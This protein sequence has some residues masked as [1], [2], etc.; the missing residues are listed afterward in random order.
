VADLSFT[1]TFHHTDWIDNVDRVQAGGPNGFNTRLT[2]IESD[3]HQL[4]TV[5]QQINGAIAAA[6]QPPPAVQPRINL[7]LDMAPGT[8]GGW[9]LD[10]NG[11]AHP[12]SNPAGASAVQ[13]VVLPDGIRLISFRAVGTFQGTPAALRVGLYRAVMS[14]P[15]PATLDTVAEILNT[16]TGFTNPFDLTIPVNASFARVDLTGFRYILAVAL[17]GA[18]TNPS[19]TSLSTVQIAYSTT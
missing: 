5:V 12:G 10:G 19:A 11:A 7:A 3:L 14:N 18:A 1:P 17:T 4:S 15:T 9:P 16:T 13:N 2:A 6:G 8:G